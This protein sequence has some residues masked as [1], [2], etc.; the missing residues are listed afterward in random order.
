MPMVAVAKAERKR[1][2]FCDGKIVNGDFEVLF[3]GNEFRG[4]LT[5]RAVHL[6]CLFA[7]NSERIPS[8]KW[9]RNVRVR[10]LAE[11]L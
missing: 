5:L 1:C 11:V 3:F 7:K 9:L 10:M 2:V 6:W 8:V 4:R